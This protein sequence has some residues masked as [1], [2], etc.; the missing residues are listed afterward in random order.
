MVDKN[1]DTLFHDTLKDIYFAEKAITKA[2]PKMAKAAHAS[3][4]RDAFTAHLEQTKGHVQRLE[5]VFDCGVG[6]VHHLPGEAEAPGFFGVL[7]EMGGVAAMLVPH[8][9]FAVLHFGHDDRTTAF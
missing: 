4:L 9:A 3:E 2:L 5:Q 6:R 1:L 8:I 7:G